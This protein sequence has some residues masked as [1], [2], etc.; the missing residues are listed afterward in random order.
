M[1]DYPG[2]AV[3]LLHVI[4]F[5]EAG[6]ATG[7]DVGMT[8]NVEEWEEAARARADALFEDARERA[9]ETGFAGD[10]V[11]R[12]VVGTPARSIVAYAEEENVDYVVMGSHGRSGVSRVLLGS[13]AE[14]VVRRA[15]CPV[16]VVR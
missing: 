9:E 10:V 16:L 7:M 14:S 2:A 6:I 13:V 1:A 4:D 12:T 8:T 11:T 5:A 3:H 15:P